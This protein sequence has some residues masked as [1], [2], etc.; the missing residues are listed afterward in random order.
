LLFAGLFAAL[1]GERGEVMAGIERYARA[2][3]ALAEQ[4][5][6]DQARL[7]DLNSSNGDPQQAAALTTELT[8]RVRIF[9]ERGH[10]LTYVCEVPTLIEQRLGTLARAI[11]A[12]I[13]D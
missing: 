11:Q 4:I 7:S 1:D 12:E 2:Q 9:N 5:R 13:P 8:T 6:A 3:K 10:S